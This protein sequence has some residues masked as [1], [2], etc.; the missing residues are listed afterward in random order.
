MIEFAVTGRNALFTEPFS[1][2]GGEKHST[3]IPNF[4]AIRGVVESIY[5]KPSINWSIEAVRVM[6][7]IK[8]E[9]KGVLPIGYTG[10][11]ILSYYTYLHD[12]SYQVRATMAPNYSRPDL[13]DDFNMPKH[14][15]MA[16]RSVN[17]GGRRDVFL[18]T[19]ECQAYV[20][21][22]VFGEN[23]SYYDGSGRLSFGTMVHGLN[24]PDK[25][26]RECLEARLWVAEMIDGVIRYPKPDQCTMIREIRPMTFP[27]TKKALQSVEVELEN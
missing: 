18:G 11:K 24:Y 9:S 1:K 6:N 15:Q 2:T 20:E 26:G 13:A 5:W 14:H 10:D 7:A 25:T 27:K 4:D 17:K 3:Q 21:P 19:R 12:V 23:N 22:C 16:L 8:M